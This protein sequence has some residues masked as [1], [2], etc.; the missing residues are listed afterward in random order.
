MQNEAQ[1]NDNE[2]P[3]MDL[4]PAHPLID[5]AA[6]LTTGAA[7]YGDR[8]WELGMS[9]GRIF[10]ALMRHLWRWWGGEENDPE[11]GHSHLAHA[12]CNI[13]F[14]MEYIRMK[15]GKD[16]RPYQTRPVE[17]KTIAEI[18]RE[19]GI[20][21]DFYPAQYIRDHNASNLNTCTGREGHSCCKCDLLDY[22]VNEIIDILG[23]D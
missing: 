22:T 16:D 1:K 3:R 11:D 2:K 4:I 15:N 12:A 18:F 5:I 6:V 21:I 8:N 13:L 17:I 20:K 23:T 10:A 19:K 7:K 9:W 14:L